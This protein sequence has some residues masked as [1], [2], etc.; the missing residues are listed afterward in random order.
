VPDG[1]AATGDAPLHL[2]RARFAEQLDELCRSHEVL[3]LERVLEDGPRLHGR[4]RAVIT[5]DD[6][7][8]GAVTA[9]VEELSRRGLPATI[10]V[11]P[12][13]LGGG[14]FWW[15]VVAGSAA[16]PAT[17]GAWREHAVHELEGRQDQVLRWAGETGLPSRGVEAHATAA[18]EEELHAACRHAGIT[19]GAH[20]WSHPN[21]ARVAG[22]E[23][24]RE[25][26]A[27]L[28]WLRARFPMTVPWMAYPYGIASAAAVRLAEA[29]GYHGA[30]LVDGGWVRPGGGDR[31]RLP[32]LTIPAQLTGDGFLLRSSGLVRR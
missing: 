20:S 6:A 19:L 26:H 7:Y 29:A 11:A 25:L 14:P 23:L 13:L 31:F 8:R 24:E 5:F 30:V 27:P 21:L 2:P 16:P 1:A 3:P 18:T 15:D 28:A 12:G 9:G 32:R 4:P 17:T 22:A 10:F